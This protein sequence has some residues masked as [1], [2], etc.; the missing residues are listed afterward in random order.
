MAQG[1][2]RARLLMLFDAFVNVPSLIMSTIAWYVCVAVALA[3]L[4]ALFAVA[5]VAIALRW[6][7]AERELMG[8][9]RQRKGPPL[10]PA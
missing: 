3:C 5:L 7:R 2:R 4:L 9:P 8:V 6:R 1:R 10:A